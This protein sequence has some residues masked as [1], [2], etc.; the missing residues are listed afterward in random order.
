MCH[1][2]SSQK[3]IICLKEIILMGKLF[4]ENINIL[5]YISFVYTIIINSFI[6]CCLVKDSDIQLDNLNFLEIEFF[7]LVFSSSLGK[8]INKIFIKI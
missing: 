2:F 8:L 7:L 5:E 1:F 6:F 3:D 4:Y